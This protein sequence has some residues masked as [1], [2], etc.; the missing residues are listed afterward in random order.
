MEFQDS[1]FWTP[2]VLDAVQDVLE[3]EAL[4][5]KPVHRSDKR[6]YI[7]MDGVRWLIRYHGTSR[8]QRF[9]IYEDIFRLERLGMESSSFDRQ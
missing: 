8:V 5:Y 3:E 1:V 6:D 4:F 2:Q 7:E 9:R